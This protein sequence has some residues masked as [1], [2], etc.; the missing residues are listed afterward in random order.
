VRIVEKRKVGMEVRLGDDIC[1]KCSRILVY[2]MRCNRNLSCLTYS[3]R[4][5][6]G[7]SFYE[8]G[9]VLSGVLNEFCRA[10]E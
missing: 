3:K 5:V 6:W 4:N 9:A 1:G 10:S 8:A 7:S 2:G